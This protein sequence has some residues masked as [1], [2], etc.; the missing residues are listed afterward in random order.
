VGT[1]GS[2]SVTGT[3]YPAP[4]FAV[5][6][7]SLP[8]GVTL[9]S[10]G[11]LSGTPA[12]NTGGV[13]TV[14]IT[15]TSAGVVT[16]ATQSFTLTVD[17]APA[18]TSNP[19]TTFTVGTVGSF[20]VTGTGYPAPTFAVTTGSLP[21]GVT[22][23]SGGTLS[24][25]PAASTG[26]V[27]TVTI[28]ATSAGVSPTA[29][30][31]F[32]LTVDQA[33]AFTSNPST[34]FT[35]GTVGSFSVTGTGYPAPTFAVTN[36]SLPT[37]VT[38]TSGGS[39]SGTPAA[40]TGGVYTVTI[41]ATSAGVSTKATQ[42]FTLTVDQAPAITSASST[43]LF[44][45]APG[46]FTVTATGYPAP[47]LSESGPLPGGVSF[48]DNGNGT[49]TISGTPTQAGAFPITITAAN[50]IGANATQSFT[51]LTGQAPAITS[52][53]SVT[54]TAGTAGSFT[55]TTT[56]YPA[57][58]LSE[59]GALLGVTFQDNGNGKATISGIPG[60]GTGGVYPITITAQNGVSPNATQSFT[61]TILQAPVILSANETTFVAGA[62][63]SFTAIATGYPAPTLSETGALPGGVSFVDSGSGAGTLAG[64]PA[65]GTSGT[66][67]IVIT[68]QNGISPNATKSFTLTVVSSSELWIGDSNNTTAAF[69]VAGAPYLTAPES[70]SGSGGVA[71][72]S[73]GNVWSVSQGSNSVAEFADTG[74]ILSSGYTGGGLSAPAAVAV[75]GS[76]QVWIVNSSNS[77]SVFNS[78]GTPVSP[79]AYTGGGLS[80]PTAIAIDISGNVWIANSGGNSVTE[81][82]GAATPTVP[83]ATGV[84]NNT[85]ATK[86]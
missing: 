31:S 74:T 79:A 33:P 2:F 82:L 68:A 17:Q 70:G 32:T 42:S 40:S 12:A 26:G 65:A 34:T 55:V 52:A 15:A 73:A 23:T 10:G 47:A 35:V 39:L 49:A 21:S 54:F 86:P 29:T 5:T 44:F 67:P 18:F 6:N 14:T 41:T 22:L 19:S 76:G 62:S 37:G 83:L 81:V 78:S 50:G 24:G 20:S 25:T 80:A 60:P 36:G 64:M 30:Q 66:Y 43:T 13:Y 27:Y 16:T 59:T 84:A 38:L 75:D 45:E 51:L 1:A 53:N 56:G 71:I 48:H 11:T 69:S 85:V 63:N 28:T 77:I 7:G 8:T 58:S 46:T 57:P 72:D 3:G 61:L 4:T 9:T